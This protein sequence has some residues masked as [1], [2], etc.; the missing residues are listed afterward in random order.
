[1][2]KLLLIMGLVIKMFISGYIGISIAGTGEGNTE[3]N[4]CIIYTSNNLYGHSM[5]AECNPGGETNCPCSDEDVIFTC[6]ENYGT[7]TSNVYERD[8]YVNAICYKKFSETFPDGDSIRLGTYKYTAQVKL[9]VLPAA[10]LN[11]RENPQAVHLMIRLWDGRN[12]FIQANDS[13]LEG[14][15]YWE[16]NPW[17]E[18]TGKIKIYTLASELIETGKIVA[19]DTNWHSFELMVDFKTQ[20][21]VYIIVDGDTIDLGTYKLARIYEPDWGDDISLTISTESLAA[22]PGHNCS[23]IFKW[24]SLFKDLK[25]TEAFCPCLLGDVNMD[26]LITP[27]DA[28]CAFRLYLNSGI[29]PPPEE[30]DTQC[31]LYCADSNCDDTITP[32]DALIIFLAYLNDLKPPLECPPPAELSLNKEI[33]GL[34]L[35]LPE[36][37]NVPPGEN[38]TVSIMVDNPQGVDAFGMDLGYPTELLSLVRVSAA[39]LTEDWQVLDGKEII[40]GVVTIGGFNPK[41]ISSTTPGVLLTVTF[42]INEGVEGNGDLWLFNLTD[43]AAKAEV[44]SGKFSIRERLSCDSEVPSDYELMQ[45]YPNPFNPKTIIAYKLPI[46]SDVELSIYNLQGQKI[47]G[48]VKGVQS[49][50]FHK[51][52]WKGRDN[53]DRSVVSGV[54][55][56]QLRAGQ[57]M[58][59]KK[60]LLLR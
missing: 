21:Y 48:L 23:R 1:M 54:Y 4:E 52:M 19:P 31:A 15:I 8:T 43:D 38:I 35:S 30:C 51:V 49:A 2:R 53:S 17:I 55:L 14:T 47:A 33:T 59:V 41:A 36:I 46:A 25:I 32:G 11:Q 57:F 29:I 58:A 12:K 18:P 34:K 6:Y 56:V 37:N 28:L 13:T 44:N 27:G 3:L 24:T 45:N 5:Y 50:G 9:P 42:K 26:S 16:L 40:A 10:D 20:D 60:M 22:W 7:V 39:D